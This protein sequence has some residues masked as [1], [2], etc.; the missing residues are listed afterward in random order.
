MAK[1]LNQTMPATLIY[2]GQCRFCVRAARRL[3]FWAGRGRLEIVPLDAPGAMELHPDLSYSK[4]LAAVQLVLPEGRLCQGAEAGL[5]A[6]SLR[7]GFAWLAFLYY[8]P[9]IRQ[10]CD[11]CYRLIA[12]GRRRCA[13]CGP[14]F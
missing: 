11:L 8:L 2:D 6:M 13:A 3:Q 4:A 7:P 12:R 14:R 1:T 10:A 9:L 5:R